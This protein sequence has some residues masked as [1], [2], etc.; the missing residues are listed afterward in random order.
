MP[1]MVGRNEAK[2]SKTRSQGLIENRKRE[3]KEKRFV[4]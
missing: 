3:L 2:I 1:P 4:Q